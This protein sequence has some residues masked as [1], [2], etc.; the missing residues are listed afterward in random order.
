MTVDR[1]P[2]ED[3]DDIVNP[4]PSLRAWRKACPECA[5]RRGDPQQLGEETLTEARRAIITCQVVFYCVHRTTADGLHRECACAAV[6]GKT[7]VGPA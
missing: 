4:D 6:M 1:E 5:F 2:W 7:P 3:P